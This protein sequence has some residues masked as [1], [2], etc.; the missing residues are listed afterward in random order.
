MPNAETYSANKVFMAGALP[1]M[2]VIATDDPTLNKLFKTAKINAV[3]QVSAK[4]DGGKEAVHF[5]VT[6][7]DWEVYQGEYKGNKKIDG[8]LAFSSMEK[9][10][11]FMK[12][13]FTKLPAIKIGNPAKFALFMAVLLKMSGI[14]T[15]T[16][17]P[18]DE[19]TQ[20]LTIK[21]FFY[22]LTTGISALNK[23]G[24]EKVSA[25][26]KK[27]PDRCYQ[28]A[29]AGYPE[30]T[31][32]LRVNQGKSKAGKGEY[33]R[34]DPFFTMLFD[35]P[36]SA[37]MILMGKGDMF[38]MTANRQLIMKGGPEFGMQLSE[39]MFYIQDLAM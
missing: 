13:D 36:E 19:A 14:L 17:I 7:G 32:Y 34:S 10:N 6:D 37:L 12:S 20:L 3:Y 39:Y 22:L 18:E 21:C 25:W 8:E 31:A 9:M 29:V 11:G 23:M 16:E 38:K 24:D 28:M 35:C 26:V 27:S 1:L 33:P 4:A 2:K 15:A 30:L 5:I